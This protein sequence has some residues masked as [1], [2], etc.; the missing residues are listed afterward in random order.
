MR[1]LFVADGRSPIALNWMA[2]FAEAG[3]AEDYEVHLASTYACR[4]ALNLASLSFVPVAFSTAAGGARGR[5]DI[6]GGKSGWR[7]ALRRAGTAGLRTALRQ[8]LGPFTLPT[9]ARELKKI[10]GE[11]QPDIVHAMRIPFEGMLSALAL[12]ETDWPLLVSVWGNDFTL[13]ATANPWMGSYTRRT[14][15]RASALHTDCQRD[16]RLAREWGFDGAK[17]ATVLPGN[18]GIRMDVFHPADEASRT[19]PGRPRSFQVINPRGFRAYVRND[20]FFRALP[21]VLESERKVRFLC[22]AMQQEPQAQRWV[23]QLGLQASVELL[24]K[25]SRLQM[26]ELFRESQ[27]AVSLSTHD[28]TPNTLLEA[29]ASGCFPIAGDIESLREWITPGVNGLLVDPGDPR[30]LARAILSALQD[31]EIRRRAALSNRQLIRER[32]E[33]QQ[34]MRQA[35]QFYHQIAGT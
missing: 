30:A 9:S 20:V 1:I 5:Q 16:L 12:S 15:R 21:G 4:P 33:Y 11:I 3:A 34:V 8:W 17:P 22:P 25:L 6:G 29:M 27:I 18:G 26:A 32:A 7:T 23:E 19:G 31:S 28:G 24:P 35:A 14:L 13:H 10:I 2:Y